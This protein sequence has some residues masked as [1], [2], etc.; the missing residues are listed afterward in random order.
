MRYN[1]SNTPSQGV[2]RTTFNK[3]ASVGGVVKNAGLFVGK[4]IETV[5]DR[6]EGYLHVE[7]FGQ[8]YVGET[9]SKAE[10]A[11]YVRVRRGSPYGGSYQFAN[12]T[13]SYGMSS[14][15]PAPGTSVLVAFPANSNTGIMVCV[16]PDITRNASVPTDPTAFVDSENN[17][18]GPTLDPSVKKQTGKN[19]K[20]RATP[21]TI[22]SEATDQKDKIN[23]SE[24]TSQGI[25]LDSI[26]GLS[27][28]SQR[29]ESPT[30]V[31]GFNTPGG[32]Q[33]VMD[34]GTLPNSDTCLTPDKE[35]EGGLSKLTRFRSAGGAQILFHDGVGI[36]YIINQNGS[37][38][39]QMGSDGK[40][41]VY[42][43]SD[44]SMHTETDFNFHCGGDFNIDADSI[45]MKARGTDGATIETATGEF[46]LHA[47][48][49]IKLTSDLNGH[50]KC[51][52]FIRET[53][54]LIDMNGPE[55][56]AATK[57]TANNLTVNRTV[58]ESITGRVPEAEPWGGHDEEQENV[59]QAASPD[60]NFAATDIDMASIMN[61]QQPAPEQTTQQKSNTR[62]ANPRAFAKDVPR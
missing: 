5:D 59:P 35:R 22:Q 15:P 44:I 23:D 29:R 50:I 2:P 27:S 62:V 34:D 24:I 46:N 60:T 20:P 42:S 10:R 49:D 39:I 1:A 51:S 33:F 3:N 25:G 41:D 32:H 9:D 12:A 57:T 30:Q 53:A 37:S 6:Y 45:N 61:N 28:S 48:K 38:W 11:N 21:E 13:N 17:A 26:R 19:K 47:N 40:I 18:I 36:V 52:G 16:L 31:F 54:S 55:A 56:T 8:G 14:H 4:V 7:I 43:E 58:K